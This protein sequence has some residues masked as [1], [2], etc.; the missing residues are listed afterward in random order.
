[1]LLNKDVIYLVLEGCQPEIEK[2]QIS[3]N[4]E[5]H[6]GTRALKSKMCILHQCSFGG[7][8]GVCLKDRGNIL[9]DTVRKEHLS[10]CFFLVESVGG[11]KAKQQVLFLPS[12]I[13]KQL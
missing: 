7:P 8:W 5:M 3:Q 9:S 6:L 10:G 13:Y 4:N 1:M 2:L 12:Q 11:S